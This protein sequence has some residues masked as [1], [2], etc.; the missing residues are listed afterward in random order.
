M[1]A[2]SESSAAVSSTL[3]GPRSEA[4]DVTKR[5]VDLNARLEKNVKDLSAD[6]LIE[7]ASRLLIS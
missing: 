2:K 5:I 6:E 4:D 7:M 3:S 1:L